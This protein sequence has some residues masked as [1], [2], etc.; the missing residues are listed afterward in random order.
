[1]CSTSSR[2]LQILKERELILIQNNALRVRRFAV[3]LS[4]WSAAKIESGSVPGRGSMGVGRR[5][6]NGFASAGNGSR[7]I[8]IW[9][10]RLCIES[11]RP[12]G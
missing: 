9:N 10:Q 5:G 1:M 2:T 3:P 8:F 7:P 11:E 6:G 4:H 12:R